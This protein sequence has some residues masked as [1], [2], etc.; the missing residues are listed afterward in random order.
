MKKVNEYAVV[1]SGGVGARLWPLSSDFMPKQL[2]AFDGDYSLLQETLLRISKRISVEKIFLVINE[3]HKFE[4]QAQIKALFK[5]KGPQILCE[6]MGKNTLPAI[7][8]AVREIM[9]VDNDPLI[10]IFPSDHSISNY[11]SFEQAWVAALEVANQGYL[12]LIGIKPTEPST[13]YGYIEVERRISVKNNRSLAFLT[14]SFHEKPTVNEAIKYV[15]DNFLWNGGMFVFSGNFFMDNL[16]Q[17]QPKLYT[18]IKSLNESN[19]FNIYQKIESESMDYGLAEKIKKI[20][21]IPCGMGWTD[22]GNWDSVYKFKDKNKDNNVTMGQS[23]LKDTKNCLIWNTQ[24]ILMT[25][26]IENLAIINTSNGTLIT[27]RAN[28]ESIKDLVDTLQKTDISEI[29]TNIKVFRPW[30]TY[31]V[32]EEGKGFKIKRIEVD[33]GKKLSLQ[34]HEHRS[35]H[36]VVVEGVA[37]VTKG[38]TSF[39]IK[40]NESAF[41]L[42]NE[43]HRLENETN[44]LLIIIEVQSGDY[45]GED[46]IKR[47][48]DD[49]NRN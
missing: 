49:Y 18:Q 22:L 7:A 19:L 30:G 17:H 40:K 32:V 41:I 45:L 27:N 20:A 12:T 4:V 23:I 34:T 1:L 3:K 26:G 2:I 16:K 15:E 28:S 48:Q 8:Y 39:L 29:S 31:T 47:Y 36:W 46:D 14:K 38:N 35:E 43:L 33:P 13:G 11:K 44:K 25:S 37:K 6:P 5:I 9:M 10:A 24:G 21:V 42:K